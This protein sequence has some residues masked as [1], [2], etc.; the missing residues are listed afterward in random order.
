MRRPIAAG[1]ASFAMLCIGCSTAPKVARP[2]APVP[3]AAKRDSATRPPAR[4]WTTRRGTGTWRYR[5]E[6]SATVVLTGDSASAPIHSLAIYSLTIDTSGAGTGTTYRVAGRV[7]SSALATGGQVPP[8][9]VDSTAA[10]FSAELDSAA[11]LTNVAMSGGQQSPCAGGVSPLVAAGLTLFVSAPSRLQQG[12]I[13]HDS[14]ATTTCRGNVAVISKLQ[15]TFELADTA[16]WNAQMVLRLNV[17]GTSTFSG[18]GLASAAG[19]SIAISGTGTSSGTLL[20]DPTSMMPVSSTMTGNSVVTVRTR[21]ATLP[22]KQSLTETVT[23]IE[24]RPSPGQP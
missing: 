3:V 16:T 22:F 19:D 7:D 12:A 1:F 21:Q 10:A 9:P 6:T 20:L 5:V 11:G 24:H 14:T 15:R 17:T 8:R 4:E 2:P 13:W 23:M 18:Q